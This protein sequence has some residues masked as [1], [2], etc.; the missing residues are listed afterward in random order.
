M[1]NARRVVC[2]WRRGDSQVSG[3]VV[4]GMAVA[5]SSN[6]GVRMGSDRRLGR[7]IGE[8]SVRKRLEGA[9]AISP[10]NSRSTAPPRPSD[11]LPYL[12]WSPILAARQADISC[13][14]STGHI[15]C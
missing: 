2:G 10:F 1:L 3:E 12:P 14:K 8:S 7:I 15:M 5:G 4:E 9:R 13:A 11:T 6:G